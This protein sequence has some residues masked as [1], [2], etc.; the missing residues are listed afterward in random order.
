MTPRSTK[1]WNARDVK[2]EQ[3]SMKHFA[4]CTSAYQN[5]VNVAA[6]TKSYRNVVNVAA[7]TKFLLP[8]SGTEDILQ[9]AKMFHTKKNKHSRVAGLSRRL[10]P[11]MVLVVTSTSR[12]IGSRYIPDRPAVFRGALVFLRNC[13]WQ[14]LKR[15]KQLL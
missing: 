13:H 8:N 9:P 11:P 10:S 2:L 6:V 1:W 3:G 7:G 4:T 15:N 12:P 5:V 14:W